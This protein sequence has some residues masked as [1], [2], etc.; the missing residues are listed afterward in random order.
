MAF[1]FTVHEELALT[2]H[3]M[4]RPFEG[5]LR[6]MVEVDIRKT[7]STVELYRTFRPATPEDCERIRLRRLQE[8]MG[9][10]N[11]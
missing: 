4:I 5:E 8:N 3:A 10:S 9:V 11:V 7:S 6:M 1:A 2:G